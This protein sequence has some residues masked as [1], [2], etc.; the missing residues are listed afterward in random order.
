[1]KIL[2]C[3]INTKKTNVKPIISNLPI[4][5]IKEFKKFGL[6][7]SHTSYFDD[8]NK[9]KKFV[10]KFGLDEKN[11]TIVSLD[12]YPANWHGIFKKKNW[13][14]K[15]NIHQKKKDL[16]MYYYQFLW[17]RRNVCNCIV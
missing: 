17:N 7:N 13:N 2:Q 16:W 8:Y 14:L 12:S 9:V 3:K 5:L 6:G 15:R 11:K 1:M 4:S 10:F